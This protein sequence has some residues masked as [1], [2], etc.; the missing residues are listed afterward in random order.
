VNNP[1]DFTLPPKMGGT[2][3]VA[4][5]ADIP[6]FDPFVTTSFG[7]YVATTPVYSRLVRAKFGAEL[8]PYDPFHA[9]YVGDLAESWT[10][11]P[12]A[13]EYT[14]KLRPG[15]K[16]QNLPPLNGRE[17]T[18]DDAKWA[19]ER[20][21][22]SDLKSVFEVVG[23]V[24]APDK[25]TLKIGLKRPASY[26]VPL[27]AENR[28][29]I[30][31][32]EI[33]DKDGDFKQTAVGTG[34]FL[35]KEFQKG[36]KLSFA[37]N[38]DYFLRGQPYLDGYNVNVVLDTAAQRAGFRGG[39]FHL[40]QGDSLTPTEQQALIRTV[41]DVVATERD[42]FKGAAVFHIDFRTDV[43][44]FNKVDVRRAISMAM[45]RPA[46][47]RG[48][49]E[50]RA[51]VMHS[52]VYTLT[53]DKPPAFEDF[54]P[55]YK[56]NPTEAR[57][58]LS[59]AGVPDGVEWEFIYFPFSA[60]LDSV[61]QLMQQQ[62]KQAGINLKLNK[63]DIGTYTAQYY[64]GRY[65]HMAYGPI[66]IFPNDPALSAYLNLHSG[67]VQNLSKWNDPRLDKLTED[68]IA[69][70]PEEQRPLFQQ[71]WDYMLDQAIFPT[72]P[73]SISF[74]YHSPKLHNVIP[75]YNNEPPHYGGSSAALWWLDK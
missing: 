40:T 41:P 46:I 61:V 27:L 75:N 68:L 22:E 65:P 44:P 45:D 25:S 26:L 6:D 73:E 59:Q 1:P 57:R 30:L 4:F 39:Q 63:V 54:G 37:K 62:M 35:H 24:E 66:R 55:Y 3:E 70:K 20:W 48:V 8:N 32:R 49:Y 71:L 7:M 52:L 21:M 53:R 47:I 11:S 34:P 42:S 10:A 23:K 74:G 5:N 72:F 31:P 9:E 2:A 15:I 60:T 28:L 17:F 33:K 64:T 16:W 56:Y 69:K 50:G 18:A 43:E 13:T 38:P 67:A 14:F 29:M 58:L 51:S 36:T 12:D 19:L